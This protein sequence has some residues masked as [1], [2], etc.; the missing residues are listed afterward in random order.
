[1]R[2]DPRLLERVGE[3]VTPLAIAKGSAK[4]PL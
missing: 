2:L 1:M 3:D 4:P